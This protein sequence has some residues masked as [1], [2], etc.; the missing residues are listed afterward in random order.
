MNQ[1]PVSRDDAQSRLAAIQS[2]N[3]K[4]ADVGSRFRALNVE[5]VALLKT[6]PTDPNFC[7][8]MLQGQG[9]TEAEFIA[10]GDAGPSPNPA[11][12]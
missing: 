8:K 6:H 1:P 4:L 12:N 3:A 11:N 9:V 5:I 2:F 10:C 7:K